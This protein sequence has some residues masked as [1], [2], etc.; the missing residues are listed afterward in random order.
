VSVAGAAVVASADGGGATFEVGAGSAMAGVAL[1]SVAGAGEVSR[2]V[3]I[4]GVESVVVVG[5]GRGVESVGG[6]IVSV[7][8]LFEF[9]TV[10]VCCEFVEPEPARMESSC[11]FVMQV[12]APLSSE[13]HR[14]LVLICLAKIFPIPFPALANHP[15]ILV[16]TLLKKAVTKVSLAEPAIG[17]TVPAIPFKLRFSSCIA[18]IA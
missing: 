16:S 13:T 14:V 9:I 18:D 11:A 1:A 12:F 5:V 3:V 17:V 15:V 10:P 4:V 7:T 8:V 6:V 2:G